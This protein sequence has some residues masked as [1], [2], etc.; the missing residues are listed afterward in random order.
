[1]HNLSTP[2]HLT[3]SKPRKP[4]NHHCIQETLDS[5]ARKMKSLTSILALAL[6]AALSIIVFGSVLPHDANDVNSAT[7]SSLT[8]DNDNASPASLSPTP[9]SLLYHPCLTQSRPTTATTTFVSAAVM[10]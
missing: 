3:Y 1:M 6:A 8:N 9:L 7:V 5:N 10:C 4:L 2:L